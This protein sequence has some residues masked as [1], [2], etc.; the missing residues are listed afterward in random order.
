MNRLVRVA[1]VRIN[2]KRDDKKAV[3]PPIVKAS[4]GL[5]A[6]Y[7]PLNATALAGASSSGREPQRASASVDNG[8]TLSSAEGK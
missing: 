1:S 6:I 3:E 4:I 5:E 7:E 8:S 2:C